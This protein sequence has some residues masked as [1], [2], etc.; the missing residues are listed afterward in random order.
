MDNRKLQGMKRQRG[1]ALILVLI[2]LA[3]GS[4]LIT[5][6]LN[7][8]HTGLIET[9]IS[10]ESLLEQYAAD[11]GVEY[12][13][14]QLRNNAGA[15]AQT[16]LQEEFTLN[17]GTVNVTVEYEG[18]GIFK[19][20]STAAGGSYGSITIESYVK[21]DVGSF[22]Y[23]V[24]AKDLVTLHNTLVDSR[25]N[26]GGGNIHANVDIKL[27]GD[28]QVDG[29]ASAV[30]EVN[31][32]DKVTGTVTEDADPIEFPSDYGELYET[33]AKEGGIHDGNLEFDAGTHYLGPLYITGNLILNPDS[34][35]V[36]E[37]PVYVVGNIEVNN[38]HLE[39]EEHVL[40]EGNIQIRGGGYA[41]ES[42]PVITAVY[43]SIQLQ[44]PTVDGVLYTPNG[45]VELLN[46]E[47]YGAIGGVQCLVNDSVITYAQELMGREDLPGSEFSLIHYAF[48]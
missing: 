28:T 38:G 37:G 24:A 13:L 46:V 41:S 27:G 21:L 2:V 17:N 22:S 12:A 39:G 16:P 18:G 43:G 34:L 8:V 9:R 5:P 44:G 45:N 33:M 15:Y 32:P 25:P 29:D 26:P 35:V 14:L 48:K 6:M 42:I 30:N 19:V 47:L 7:Y 31:N 1:T 3:L 36:L 20:T 10:K 23:A 11:S 40:A 4:L